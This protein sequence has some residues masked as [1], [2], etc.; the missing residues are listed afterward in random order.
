MYEP[1]Q[2]PGEPI[3][4]PPPPSRGAGT[5]VPP[6]VDVPAPPAAPPPYR[7]RITH[8][9]SYLMSRFIAFVIDVFGVAFVLATFGLHFAET[10]GVPGPI[11]LK[12]FWL[13]ASISFLLALLI[14]F[15][16][17]GLFATTLGKLL[18]GLVVRNSNGGYAGLGR[19]LTRSAFRPIDLV[20]IGPLLALVTPK[21]QRLGD[22]AAG[23]VVSQTRFAPVM[24]FV[25]AAAIAAIGY[26][27]VVW[28]GGLASAISVAAQS[29][30]T[31]SDLAQKIKAAEPNLPVI[32]PSPAGSPSL[33]S[34]PAP[35]NASPE[36][37]ASPEAPAEATPEAV[38]P[39]PAPAQTG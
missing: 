11:D 24:T 19:A 33:E 20:L 10:G 39:T 36:P 29:L 18:F 5:F 12:N 1:P 32:S 23:T 21:R 37:A 26:A 31:G 14:A 30:A 22:L 2:P 25:A 15:L 28:G 8:V 27:E 7:P 9:P 35:A 3:V 6:P 4:E 34:S 38:A 13:L 17:E 16:C